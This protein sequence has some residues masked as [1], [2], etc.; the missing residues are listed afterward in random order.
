MQQSSQ[1][2]KHQHK[3]KVNICKN[4]NLTH[5]HNKLKNFKN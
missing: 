3:N 4:H 5:Y 1:D 2:F